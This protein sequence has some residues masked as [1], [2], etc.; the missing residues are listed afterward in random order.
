MIRQDALVHIRT[1][2]YRRTDA[3]RRCLESL[4]AQS[5]PDWVCDVFDDDPDGSGRSVCEEIADPRIRYNHNRTQKFA[6]LNIDQCFSSDN[7]HGAEYFCVV[8]DDNYVLPEFIESNIGIIRRLNVDLV[9]RNQY[10]EFASGTPDARLSE[11]GIFDEMFV[12]R[13]YRPDEFRLS[14]I[15]GIGVSNGALFWSRRARSRLE[16][17]FPCTATLQEYMRTFSIA[18]DIHVAMTPLAVWAQNGE[19]TTRDLGGGA[20]YLRR[21]LDLKRAIQILQQRSWALADD[22]KRRSFLET[23]LFAYPPRAR[24]QGLVKALIT[25]RVGNLLKASEKMELTARGLLIRGAGNV[26]EDFRKFLS[27]RAVTHRH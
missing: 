13:T 27:S 4:R 14:V 16:I 19:Q 5:W 9:L 15:P 20:S 26:P 22:D 6:S 8:E 23:D 17:G 3:L 18:E 25:A 21:E 7:P 1:P 10:V 2:T 24:A 12:E 11:F